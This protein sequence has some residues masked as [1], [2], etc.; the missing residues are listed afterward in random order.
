M[1]IGSQAQKEKVLE[2]VEKCRGR[3][4]HWLVVAALLAVVQVVPAAEQ[5]EST[6]AK[7][8]TWQEIHLPCGFYRWEFGKKNHF[9]ANQIV[10]LADNM[11]AAQNTDGGWGKNWV[12]LSMDPRPKSLNT[13]SKKR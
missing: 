1:Q 8:R 9:R 4:H 12:I 6:D 3:C 5:T 13:L 10:H 7:S 2:M 11:M